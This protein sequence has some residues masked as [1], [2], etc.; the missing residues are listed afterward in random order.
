MQQL[1]QS[2]VF[3]PIVPLVLGFSLFCDR[4]NSEPGK[5]GRQEVKHHFLDIVER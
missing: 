2:V 3:F 5:Q 1:E 4:D